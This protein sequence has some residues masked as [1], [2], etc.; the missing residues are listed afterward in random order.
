MVSVMGGPSF[1]AEK[2]QT[3]E[4]SASQYLFNLQIGSATLNVTIEQVGTADGWNVSGLEVHLAGETAGAYACQISSTH[5]MIRAGLPA[6]ST[7][8]TP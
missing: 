4:N 6:F 3:M 1:T 7:T 2:L 8:C 5:V